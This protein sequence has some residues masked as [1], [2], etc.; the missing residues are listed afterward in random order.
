MNGQY[1]DVWFIANYF[2]IDHKFAKQINRVASI[3]SLTVYDDFEDYLFWMYKR[4]K[5]S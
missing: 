5:K 2:D 4:A 1:E 3:N